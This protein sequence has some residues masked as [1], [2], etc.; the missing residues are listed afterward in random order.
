MDRL[1]F[2]LQPVLACT[3]SMRAADVVV[4]G[5]PRRRPL[6]R[7][8]G[9]WTLGPSRAPRCRAHGGSR[10]RQSNGP[11]A[12]RLQ[13]RRAVTPSQ[14]QWAQTAVAAALEH[15][16]R[17]TNCA[18]AD[19]VAPM[20]RPP[21]LTVHVGCTHVIFAH[22][23]AAAWVVVVVLGEPQVAALLAV[24][25]RANDGVVFGSTQ[26]CL[27][28]VALGFSLARIKMCFQA[29]RRP[30]GRSAHGLTWLRMKARCTRRPQRC[31]EPV[32][33]ERRTQE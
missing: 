8:P 24:E 25:R 17:E 20:Y 2:R 28:A 5:Y 27:I 10:R 32:N 4:I 31:S 21:G 33:V 9:C 30:P 13:L 14:A 22:R 19:A 26:L 3:S 15:V 11:A 6:L 12:R 29:V 18:R 1:R 16:G 23:E 7:R